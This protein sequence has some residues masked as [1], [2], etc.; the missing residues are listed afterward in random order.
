MEKVKAQE[1]QNKKKFQV[2]FASK[3][4]SADVNRALQNIKG[5]VNSDTIFLKL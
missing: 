5:K 2:E 1:I 3:K 4:S